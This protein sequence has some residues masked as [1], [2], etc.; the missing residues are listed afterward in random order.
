MQNS[1]RHRWTEKTLSSLWLGYLKARSSVHDRVS[2]LKNPHLVL[3]VAAEPECVRWR[4]EHQSLLPPLPQLAQEHPPHHLFLSVG[5]FFFSWVYLR[6]SCWRLELDRSSNSWYCADPAC[7]VLG[8]RSV[9]P[10]TDTNQI[11]TKDG[12]VSLQPK[13]LWLTKGNTALHGTE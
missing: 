3:I 9:V 4:G 7:P 12:F 5:M 10:A 11:Q 8:G 2:P 1:L 13:E 6:F